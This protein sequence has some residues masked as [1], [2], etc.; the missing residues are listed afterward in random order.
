MVNLI[1]IL[2]TALRRHVTFPSYFLEVRGGRAEGREGPGQRGGQEAPRPGQLG[3]QDV[4]WRVRED[5]QLQ[6]E[7]Q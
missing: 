1:Y 6:H 3:A 4:A 5:G 7:G 2:P